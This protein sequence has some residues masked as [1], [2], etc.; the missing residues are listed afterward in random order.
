MRRV[1]VVLHAREPAKRVFFA[2]H[3]CLEKKL[4]AS[5]AEEQGF[6][7]AVALVACIVVACVK[8]DGVLQVSR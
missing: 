8:S 1:V 6:E 3:R 5:L 2:T 4:S 7:P